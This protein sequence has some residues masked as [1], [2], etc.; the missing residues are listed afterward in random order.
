MSRSREFEHSEPMRQAQA[1]LVGLRK[2]LKRL[3]WISRGRGYDNMARRELELAR[4]KLD[5]LEHWLGAASH[6]L[7]A[8]G[9]RAAKLGFP[10]GEPEDGDG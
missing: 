4:V 9:A 8:G 2:R 6:A 5:E 1:D 10:P 7:N 3:H